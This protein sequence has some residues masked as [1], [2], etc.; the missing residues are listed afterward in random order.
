MDRDASG[1]TLGPAGGHLDSLTSVGAYERRLRRIVRC[2]KFAQLPGLAAPLGDRLVGR[3]G[4]LAVQVDWVVPV[5][6]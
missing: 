2:L 3:L 5:P 1:G 4:P 6:L